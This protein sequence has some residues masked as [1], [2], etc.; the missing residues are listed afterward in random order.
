MMNG[1]N[2]NHQKSEEAALLSKLLEDNQ[3]LHK[4]EENRLKHQA[5]RKRIYREKEKHKKIDDKKSSNRYQQTHEQH[6]K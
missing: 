5:E 4:K 1:Y 3:R 2:L 6:Q